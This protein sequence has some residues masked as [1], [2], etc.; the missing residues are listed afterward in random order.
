[1]S[2]KAIIS[3]VV[4]LFLAVPAALAQEGP[5]LLDRG[6]TASDVPSPIVAFGDIEIMV[7]PAKGPVQ[8]IV[9]ERREYIVGDTKQVD[10]GG[11]VAVQTA[12]GWQPS[13]VNISFTATGTAFE[14]AELEDSFHIVLDKAE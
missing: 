2:R 1:M 5:I 6:T 13:N 3:F 8:G 14:D 10:I 4:A 11:L 7:E 9:S 12:D